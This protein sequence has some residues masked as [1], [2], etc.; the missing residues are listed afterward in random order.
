[1]RIKLPTYTSGMLKSVLKA[2]ISTLILIIVSYLVYEAQGSFVY[3]L[4]GKANINFS[5]FHD[6]LAIFTGKAVPFTTQI[7][8]LPYPLDLSYGYNELG[9][10]FLC[11]IPFWLICGAIIAL[12]AENVKD[13]IVGLFSQIMFLTF[14]LLYFDQVSSKVFLIGY[15]III[16]G[17]FIVFRIKRAKL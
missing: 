14:L 5:S 8:N 6:F 9:F 2:I 4:L 7:N 3:L 12:L 13:L 10:A 1:M 11:F 17:A 16:V 15:L